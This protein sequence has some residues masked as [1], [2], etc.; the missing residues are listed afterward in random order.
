MSAESADSILT[1]EVTRNASSSLYQ[2]KISSRAPTSFQATERLDV[3]A[4][5]GVREEG[6][7]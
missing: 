5:G 7:A 3:H 1:S 2:D 6:K 4:V